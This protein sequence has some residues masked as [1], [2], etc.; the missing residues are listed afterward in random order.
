M[1]RKGYSYTC[2][3]HEDICGSGGIAPLV[4]NLDIRRDKWSASRPGH[5][6]ALAQ[7]P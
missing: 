3:P 6:I 5:F 4:L 1:E 2:A 7:N